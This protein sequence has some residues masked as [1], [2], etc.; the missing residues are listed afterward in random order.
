MTA[1]LIDGKAIA[2]KVR[3]EIAADVA[4]LGRIGLA[5]VLVGDDPA[6]HVYINLKHKA[7]QEAGIRAL[8]RRL[9]SDISQEELL[10]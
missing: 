6:S 4:R 10:A 2:A 5:T 3:E 8:D 9:P 1:T 7:A